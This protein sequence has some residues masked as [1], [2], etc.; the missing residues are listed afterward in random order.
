[1]PALFEPGHSSSTG[2]AHDSFEGD[3]DERTRG[4]GPA[5]LHNEGLALQ[6]NESTGARGLRAKLLQLAA[7]C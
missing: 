4:G 1:M 3:S 7:R 6:Q 2:L 5:K